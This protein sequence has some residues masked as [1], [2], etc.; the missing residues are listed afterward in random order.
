[1]LQI[2]G[3]EF[4]DERCVG[5]GQEGRRIGAHASLASADRDRATAHQFL[6][7]IEA[8]PPV[9]DRREP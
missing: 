7:I 5:T 6:C 9:P 4:L 8:D 1:M 3:V 2:T